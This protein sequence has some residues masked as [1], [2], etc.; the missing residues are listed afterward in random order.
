MEADAQHRARRHAAFTR[1]AEAHRRAA[2]VEDRAVL[3]FELLGD[4][5]AA[6][7]HRAAS[8]RQSELAEADAGRAARWA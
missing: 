3:Q 4:V 5:D 6:E 7:C 1:A 8:R 2:E